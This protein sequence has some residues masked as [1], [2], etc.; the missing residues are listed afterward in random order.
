MKVNTTMNTVSKLVALAVF[1]AGAATISIT[2]PSQAQIAGR[3]IPGGIVPPAA[4]CCQPA[5]KPVITGTP[6]WSVQPPTGPLVN[7]AVLVSSPSPYWLTI[8]GSRWIAND[9]SA[10]QGQPGGVYVYSYHF[11]LC[12]GVKGVPFP[13]TMSLKVFADDGFVA[14]LNGNPIGSHPG[15]WGFAT[16]PPAPS[17]AG[18]PSTGTPINVASQYFRACDNV[19]TFEVTNDLTTTSP[20]G[21]DVY[22]SVNGYFLPTDSRGTCP[23]K[24]SPGIP[25]SNSN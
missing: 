6:G 4:L 2:A 9:A 1:A 5:S 14:K 3:A 20:T 18:S 7:P 24:G 21:L 22:G 11:C 10:G 25:N 17:G 23:C 13:A 15:G 19:L 8:L 16:S 12:P